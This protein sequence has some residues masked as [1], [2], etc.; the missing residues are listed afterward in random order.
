MEDE[1]EKTLHSLDGIERAEPKPFLYTRIQGR[2]ERRRAD[3]YSRIWQL[4]PAY[5]IASV[6]LLIVLNVAAILVYNRSHRQ[7]DTARPSIDA[8][9]SDY[10]LSFD[11]Q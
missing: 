6:A 11:I 9:A 5:V 1:I 8:M 3:T 7:S 10:G 2:I 4:K